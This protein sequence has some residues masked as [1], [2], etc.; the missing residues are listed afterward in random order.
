MFK[1][2]RKPQSKQEVFNMQMEKL[3]IML[4]FYTKEDFDNVKFHKLNSDQILQFLKCENFVG[5]NQIA[6][7]TKVV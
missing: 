4:T 3:R 6:E 1:G 2:P 7:P 5:E